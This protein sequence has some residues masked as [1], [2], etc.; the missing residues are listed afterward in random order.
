VHF[1]SIFDRKMCSKKPKLKGVR[2]S[3]A[4]PCRAVLRAATSRA[5]LRAG[6]LGVRTAAPSE[7]RTPS[8]LAHSPQAVPRPEAPGSLPAPHVGPPRA[9]YHGREHATPPIG[10]TPAPLLARRT[11]AES[12]PSSCRHRQAAPLFK[13]IHPP[14]AR[15]LTVNNCIKVHL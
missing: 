4:A 7:A 11:T 10:P 3:R 14:R 13:A 8:K 15:L 2:A 6:R 12:T 9:P 5:R 1:S